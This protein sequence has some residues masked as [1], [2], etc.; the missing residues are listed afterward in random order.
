MVKANL[1]YGLLIGSGLDNAGGD[2]LLEQYISYFN[3]SNIEFEAFVYHKNL[4]G[5]GT[6]KIRN[7]TQITLYDKYD[8][9]LADK[10]NACDVVIVMNSPKKIFA[11][12]SEQFI[13]FVE[14]LDTRVVVF[15][16]DRT[17]TGFKFSTFDPRIL[18]KAIIANVFVHE[19]TV[20]HNELKKFPQ[21]T[22]TNWD[23]NLFDF[24]DMTHV[25]HS[26]KRNEITFVGRFAS[27][28]GARYMMSCFEKGLLYDKFFYTM[29]GSKF[30]YDRN[31]NTVSGSIGDVM[32]FTDYVANGT[33]K[34]KSHF[35]V[36]D[37]YSQFLNVED[38]TKLTLYPEYE[39]S[40]MLERLKYAK[41]LMYLYR[42][43]KTGRGIFKTGLEYA[44]FES[45]SVGTPVITTKAYGR[46]MIVDGKPLIEHDCGL[47]FVESDLS[48]LKQEVDLYERNYDANV[49]KM[50]KFFLRI[51][52]NDKRFK[53]MENEIKTHSVR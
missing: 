25:E 23:I 46:E 16:I 32:T 41:Y 9:V 47:I 11:L 21:L 49:E 24:D 8:Y 40:E 4:Y 3:K 20:W 28:K 38:Y 29:Q 19:G 37:D 35:K 48:D 27:L 42:Y 5:F 6:L 45:I 53:E 31:S 12:E 22:I 14:T 18:G 10:M 30:N 33:K 17:K 51:Y 15:L 43:G 36:E 52:E 50:Q 2:T 1:K 26:M 7:I 13:Q 34:L 39:K 44:V